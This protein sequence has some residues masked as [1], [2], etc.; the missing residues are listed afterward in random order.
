VAVSERRFPHGPEVMGII[1]EG[2]LVAI[3]LLSFGII[4]C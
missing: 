3:L 1:V 4:R 2:L